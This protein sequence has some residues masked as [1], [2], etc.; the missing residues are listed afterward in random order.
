VRP[1]DVSTHIVLWT[2]KKVK[3]MSGGILERSPP[4]QLIQRHM[5]IDYSV[6]QALRQIVGIDQALVVYDIC[7]QWSLH[8]KQ[9]VDA[10]TF[11]SL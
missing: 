4:T 2:F 3:G 11:L 5:N 7:C 9:R 10:G 8:F 1:M 6:C